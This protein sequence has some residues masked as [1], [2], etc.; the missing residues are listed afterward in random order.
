MCG[1]TADLNPGEDVLVL[2]MVRLPPV[3]MR[4]IGR[5]SHQLH[6]SGQPR[7]QNGPLMMM[8]TAL[9]K[10]ADSARNR[11]RRWMPSVPIE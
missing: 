5:L 1:W 6:H 11:P 3:A 10:P 8:Q 2:A 7:V 9:Q 4:Q